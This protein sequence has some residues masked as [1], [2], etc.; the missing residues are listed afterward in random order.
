MMLKMTIDK[1]LFRPKAKSKNTDLS[2]FLIVNPN[3]YIIPR[4]RSKKIELSFNQTDKP[5]MSGLEQL[6]HSKVKRTIELIDL[7]FYVFRRN[8]WDRKA[9]FDSWE[10]P[11]GFF[12]KA[13]CDMEIDLR[14]LISKKICS[15][16]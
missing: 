10:A 4:T 16:L 1:G 8:E 9:V 2:K 11:Q 13:L 5:F 12:V 15:D 14:L 6:M 7:S 3:G